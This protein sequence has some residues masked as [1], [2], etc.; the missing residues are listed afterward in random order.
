MKFKTMHPVIDSTITLRFI[1]HDPRRYKDPDVF[2]PS[3]FLGE[4]PEPDP[5]D[6][7]FGY[8][9]RACSGQQLAETSVFLACATSLAALQ[10]SRERD[11]N[12]VEIVPK[13]EF[14][15]GILSYVAFFSFYVKEL[16]QF[17]LL[18]G[19]LNHL[20]VASKLVLN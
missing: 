1:L 20:H 13:A 9:R 4:N 19:A 8:G 5:R 2:E 15:S 11:T 12:N 6:H 16:T 10:I 18:V 14:E 17:C 3:R 7:V